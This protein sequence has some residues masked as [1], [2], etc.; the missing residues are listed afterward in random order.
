MANPID[1]NLQNFVLNCNYNLIGYTF[2]Q[3]IRFDLELN[4]ASE[5]STSL[6][7][8][9]GS[10]VLSTSCSKLKS[11][12]DQSDSFLSM[13]LCKEWPSCSVRMASISFSLFTPRK[14]LSLTL[15]S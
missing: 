10:I 1:Q 9:L 7:V 14:C 11:I 12:I 4:R 2:F 5:S 15:S 3:S 8:S 13:N 6:H